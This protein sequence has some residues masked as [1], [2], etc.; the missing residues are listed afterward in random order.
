VVL[1]PKHQTNI[2]VIQKKIGKVDCKV[3]R[4]RTLLK[5]LQQIQI[6]FAKSKQQVPTC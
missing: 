6:V 1:T 4:E 3:A 2:I 5:S